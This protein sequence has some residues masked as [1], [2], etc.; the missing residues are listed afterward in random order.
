MKEQNGVL[1]S[2]IY[3][4]FAFL[5]FIT[6]MIL[7]LCNVINWSWWWVTAPLWA[8]SA[9]SAAIMVIA[10]LVYL[11]YEPIRRARVRKNAKKMSNEEWFKHFMDG[12]FS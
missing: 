1:N 10:L 7:K 3:S 6:F 4:I 11:I 2:L 8:G 9:I 12:D 5:L